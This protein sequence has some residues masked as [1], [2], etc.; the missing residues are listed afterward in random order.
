MFKNKEKVI[1][2]INWTK[3]WKIY[4][5]ILKECVM[6]FLQMRW[7]QSSRPQSMD[8]AMIF[9]RGNAFGTGPRAESGGWAPRTPVNFDNLNIFLNRIANIQYWS[10]F[11][12][13]I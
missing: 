11:F 8:E 5:L 2:E 6:N 3:D 7:I 4:E 10:V 1:S 13:N 12:N 9:D